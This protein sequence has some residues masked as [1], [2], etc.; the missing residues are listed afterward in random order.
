MTARN[1]RRRGKKNRRPLSRHFSTE[2]IH[3]LVNKAL[4]EH[5][6]DDVDET[7]VLG[8]AGYLDDPTVEK[9]HQAAPYGMSV[10]QVSRILHKHGILWVRRGHFYIP[11]MR[12]R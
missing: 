2:K 5:Q 3:R 7:T 9:V 6:H 10:R 12:R 8:I 11:G 4:D 1:R